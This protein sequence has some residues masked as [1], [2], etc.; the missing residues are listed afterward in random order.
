LG[1]HR[2]QEQFPRALACKKGTLIYSGERYPKKVR[3]VDVPHPDYSNIVR[4]FQA[5]V[6]DGPDS[7]RRDRV[8]VISDSVGT[9]FESQELSHGIITSAVTIGHAD[10]VGAGDFNTMSFEGGPISVRSADA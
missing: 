9:W 10:H 4:D 7:L 3:I 5:C 8:V 6:Q 2:A 1:T